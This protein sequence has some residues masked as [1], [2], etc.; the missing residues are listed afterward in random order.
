MMFFFNYEKE[1]PQKNENEILYKIYVLKGLADSYY[2]YY[3]AYKSLKKLWNALKNKYNIK[4]L[5][6]KIIL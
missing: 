5:C 4:K 3:S 2:N 6:L 1:L